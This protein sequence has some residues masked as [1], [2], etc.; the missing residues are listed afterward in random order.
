MNAKVVSKENNM[1]K[2]SFQVGPEKLE[3][4]L[5]HAY[6][7]NKNHL[8]ISGFR[9]GKAPRKLIESQ[10]GAEIFY[11][12]AVNFILN[13]E[14][15]IAVKELELDTVSRPQ[16]D[17]PVI[18]KATGVTFEVEVTVKPSVKLGQY[19]GLEVEKADTTVTDEAVGAELKKVQEKNARMQTIEDRPAQMGDVVNISYMGTVDGVAFEGG[20]ADSY[21]LTLGSH[22]FIDTFEDQI[23]G[24]SIGD[25][26]DV[27]VTF[28]AEY[29]A[30]E[31][32][33]KEAVFAVELK[34]I[35]VNELPEL[36]DEFAQDVSEFETLAEYKASVVDK[37]KEAAEA[38][39]KQ[40]QGDQLLDMAVA[41]ATMDVPEVMYENKIDQMLQDFSNNVSKQ[42][43]SVEVYCQY[44]GTTPEGLRET[45]RES[46]V[47]SVRARLMLEQIA[48]EEKIVATEEEL[49]EQIAK[50]G[51]GYGIAPE[52]M[53]EIFREEDKKAIADDLAVQKAL[54]VIEDA[55]IIVEPKVV[56]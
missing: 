16:I 43:L 25:K 29:H 54:K 48:T 15:D 24:H 26:F 7:K 22:S 31:L 27:N 11:D 12:D 34:G 35:S 42:G 3:E 46:A 5:K 17:A 45:F 23:V 21:D 1:V 30:E 40:V 32:K 52:K 8:S 13:T 19:K 4:G 41:N 28:P 44:L 37:L 20:T 47:K 51:E 39:A 6:N 9:K 49:N 33:A 18:D 14:Y 2:F 53:L 36:N 10:Y 50:I 38:N 56:E 55:A